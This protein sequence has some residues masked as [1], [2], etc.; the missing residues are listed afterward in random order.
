MSFSNSNINALNSA[1]QIMGE[2]E[3][4]QKKISSGMIAVEEKQAQVR[5]LINEQKERTSN[6][7]KNKQLL[8][9]KL[10]ETE[11]LFASLNSASNSSGE[12]HNNYLRSKSLLNECKELKDNVLKEH[13]ILIIKKKEL[14]SLH[15]SC[16]EELTALNNNKTLYG[17]KSEES[18]EILA[19]AMK[20]LMEK[21]EE[22][23][24]SKHDDKEKAKNAIEI[25]NK[26]LSLSRS[27]EKT[28][29]KNTSGTSPFQIQQAQ[30][31]ISGSFGYDFQMNLSGF[32]QSTNLTKEI[33]QSTPPYNKDFGIAEEMGFFNDIENFDNNIKA[34][35]EEENYGGENDSEE[36]LKS[37][38]ENFQDEVKNPHATSE[39]LKDIQIGIEKSLSNETTKQFLSKEI[40]FT[41]VKNALSTLIEIVSKCEDKLC[42][43]KNQFIKENT[44]KAITS[45][46][47]EA[48][49]SPQNRL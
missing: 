5:Q 1:Q 37:I 9:I 20:N 30:M 47:N 39:F 26:L 36:T 44:P 11:C 48:N 18:S 14:E 16:A 43:L 35:L 23:V 15:Q 12:I 25:V 32:L 21:K 13:E 4:L 27:I 49:I 29:L 22:H 34:Q 7:E 6:L 46:D 2:C 28:A 42:H 45:P 10:I 40:D 17:I 24:D 19:A 41:S 31:G 8:E 38:V 3:A 33:F